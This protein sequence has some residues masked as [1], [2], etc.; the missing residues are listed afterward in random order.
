MAICNHFV[1]SLSL[2]SDHHKG[3]IVLIQLVTCAFRTPCNFRT[4]DHFHR[5]WQAVVINLWDSVPSGILL[6]GNIN[7]WKTVLQDMQRFIVTL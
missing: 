2:Q 5:S 4:L 1:L 3:Y 6:Q 7:G